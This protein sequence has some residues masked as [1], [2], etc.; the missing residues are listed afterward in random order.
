MAVFQ[1][2]VYPG[3][4][5]LLIERPPGV[6]FQKIQFGNERGGR[7]VLSRLPELRIARI[8]A[9]L[10]CLILR[11]SVR[12]TEIFWGFFLGTALPNFLL[13]LYFLLF[14]FWSFLGF[15]KSLREGGSWKNLDQRKKLWSA[16]PTNS[17]N[18]SRGVSFEAEL[19]VPC[20]LRS[21]FPTPLQLN[22]RI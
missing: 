15:Q 3:A 8:L 5:R 22:S 19:G 2:P 10:R 21:T 7:S 18:F 11:L 12:H 6:P 20:I 9:L 14:S 13:F 1:L 17:Q 4:Q 16:V